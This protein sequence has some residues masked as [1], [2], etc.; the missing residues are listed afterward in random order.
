MHFDAHFVYFW[1]LI[2]IFTIKG[3]YRSNNKI[4]DNT[5]NNFHRSDENIFF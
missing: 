3:M 2:I 4:V 1:Q 5:C